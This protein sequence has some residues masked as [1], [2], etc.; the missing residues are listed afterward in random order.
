MVGKKDGKYVVWPAYFDINLSR[1][2]G[3]RVSKKLAVEN[4]TL[5]GIA[6]AAQSLGLHPVVE[7]E[8]RYPSRQWDVK[9]RVL[10]DK[11]ESKCSVLR[12]IASRL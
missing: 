6:K 7:K 9:G 4:P 2:E 1:G 3:R 11:V 8:V 12:K 5:E 10:V